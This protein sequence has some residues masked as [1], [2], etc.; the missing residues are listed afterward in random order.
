MGKPD[1]GE[2]GN[3]AA[4]SY[5]WGGEQPVKSQNHRTRL[6]DGMRFSKFPKILQDAMIATGK[7]DMRYIWIDCII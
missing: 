4:L 7:M 2:V 5:C 1:E 6:P 3:Y